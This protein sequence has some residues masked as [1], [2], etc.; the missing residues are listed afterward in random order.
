MPDTATLAAWQVRYEQ[1]SFWRNRRAAFFSL[2]F[3]LM[4]LVVFGLLTRGTT[5]DTRGHLAMIDFYVPGIVAYA[6]VLIGFNT[7][8]MQFATRR[9]NGVFKRIRTTPLPW[10]AY[11]GGMLGSTVLVVALS[12]AIM[13]VVGTTVFD[14]S[15]RVETLPGLL[16]TLVLGTACFTTL[17]VAAS[18][19]VAKPEN[20]IGILIVITLPLTFISNVW[21]PIDDAPGWVRDLAGAFPLKPLADGIATAFDPATAAPGLAGHDLLVLALWTAAGCAMMANTMRSLAR[22]A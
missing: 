15:F 18:R 12:V 21:F 1:R 13:L 5:L 6:I 16:A 8:A 19:V 17:G 7:T 22:R 20:G 14:A 3:P 11:V 4:Y 2:A 9:A 10:A